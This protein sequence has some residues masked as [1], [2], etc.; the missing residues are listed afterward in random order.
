MR[1]DTATRAKVSEVREMNDTDRLQQMEENWNGDDKYAEAVEYYL[2]EG[3]P[4]EIAEEYASQQ[5]DIDD[6]EAR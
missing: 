5:I 1:S 6:G 3:Y 4:Q 2:D